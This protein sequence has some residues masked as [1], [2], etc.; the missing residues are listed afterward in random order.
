MTTARVARP[1]FLAFCANEPPTHHANKREKV[2]A[3]ANFA[4]PLQHNNYTN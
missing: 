3:S 4:P 1:V 2:V